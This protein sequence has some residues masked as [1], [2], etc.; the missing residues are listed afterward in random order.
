VAHA[1]SE[2]DVIAQLPDTTTVTDSEGG[3]HQVALNWSVPGYDRLTPGVYTAE[4]EAAREALLDQLNHPQSEAFL[5]AR[6]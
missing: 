2:A 4:G 5:D 3:V 1:T 6:S